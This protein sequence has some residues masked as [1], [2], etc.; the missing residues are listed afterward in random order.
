MLLY[1]AETK[2][3]IHDSLNLKGVVYEPKK[4]F[5]SSCKRFANIGPIFYKVHSLRSEQ[6][7]N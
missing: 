4:I 7:F 5:Q 2:E 6:V 1:Y 3:M